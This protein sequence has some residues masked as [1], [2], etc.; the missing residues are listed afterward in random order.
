[1]T[2]AQPFSPFGNDLFGE[3][4]RAQTSSPVAQKFL[5]PPFSVL[6][7]RDGDWQDRKR[8]WAAAICA[9]QFLGN[10]WA[11]LGKVESSGHLPAAL[12]IAIAGFMGSRS[13]ALGLR[14]LD[15]SKIFHKTHNEH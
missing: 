2:T 13:L 7:A 9:G 14:L 6:S 8:A 5:V 12:G 1:M 15:T 10:R 11:S 3:P 4:I